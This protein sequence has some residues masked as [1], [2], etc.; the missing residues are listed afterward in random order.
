MVLRHAHAALAL[1]RLDQDRGRLRPDR[2]LDRLEIAERHLVEALDHRAEAFEVFLLSARRERRERAA[3]ERAL[4]GDDAIA[5]GLPLT[6][7]NLRA[8]LIAP[9]IAS[10]PELQKKT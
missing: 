1:D 3:V 10:A 5:L 2:L 6:A 7:W 8:V 9:S 4:E